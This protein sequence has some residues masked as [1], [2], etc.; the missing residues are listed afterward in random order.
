MA[1]LERVGSVEQRWQETWLWRD[2][3]GFAVEISTPA[4]IHTMIGNWKKKKFQWVYRTFG[5]IMLVFIFNPPIYVV[6][7]LTNSIKRQHCRGNQ[8]DSNM[9]TLCNLLLSRSAPNYP[10][11]RIRTNDSGRCSLTVN[12]GSVQWQTKLAFI[13]SSIGFD[14]LFMFYS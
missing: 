5:S 13:I 4:N 6:N 14:C 1:R 10:F 3:P 11:V 2:S 7:T 12:P 9:W 8:A